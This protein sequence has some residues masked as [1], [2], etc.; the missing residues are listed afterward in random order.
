MFSNTDLVNYFK[1]SSEI[2][3]NSVVIAEWNLNIPGVIDKV[4]NYRYRPTE[5][6]SLY[7]NLPN[8]YECRKRQ[9]YNRLVFPHSQL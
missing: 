1:T 8:N 3:L 6:T 2:S 5:T 7:S 9:R 4:G